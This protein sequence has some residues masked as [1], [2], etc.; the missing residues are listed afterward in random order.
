MRLLLDT[1]VLLW[2]LTD[3]ARLGLPARVLIR[4]PENLVF[5]SAA[6][7]WEIRIKQ[8]I[9]K[10]ELGAQFEE[11]LA[12]EPFEHLSVTHAHAHALAGLPPHHR[13]P[14]DRILIAQALTED[15]TLLTHDDAVRR[16]AVKSIA[17]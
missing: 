17:A 16:Y 1:H 6:T 14:F 11:Q 9:G 13:D 4:E 2:W 5:V 7:I 15:L 8:G 12:R 3:D 10:L